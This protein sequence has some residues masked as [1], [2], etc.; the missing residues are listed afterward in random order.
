MNV[1]PTCRRVIESNS[2]DEHDHIIESVNISSDEPLAFVIRLQIFCKNT[3]AVARKLACAR[4][5][6]KEFFPEREF[7]IQPARMVMMPTLQKANLP[8]R[9]ELYIATY[10]AFEI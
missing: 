6:L 2:D 7:E 4:S 3:S 9:E 5:E 1:C 10:V 8:V